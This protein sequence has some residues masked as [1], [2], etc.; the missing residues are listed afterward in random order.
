[1]LTITTYHYYYSLLHHIHTLQGEG[2]DDHGGPYR[3]LFQSAVGEEPSGILNLLE[4]CPNGRHRVGHNQDSTVFTG[5]AAASRLYWHLG[6]LLGTAGRHDIQLPLS[7]SALVWKPC[8]GAPLQRADLE[9]VDKMLAR[10]LTDIDACRLDASDEVAV[11][12]DALR[13]AGGSVSTAAITAA[14]IVTSGIDSDDGGSSGSAQQLSAAKRRRLVSTVERLSMTRNSASLEELYSGIGAV[15]PVEQL[16]VFTAAEAEALFC[17]VP[18]V[19]IQ[20]VANTWYTA[21]SITA[22][23]VTQCSEQCT[24]SL[25]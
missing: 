23:I 25:L 19:S 2:V 8:V 20:S 12:Q 14:T 13:S 3:A 11:L 1:M 22:Y 7:L 4:P 24:V 9:S 10:G 17:G 6:R 16:A 15:L 21:R 5:T 18:E